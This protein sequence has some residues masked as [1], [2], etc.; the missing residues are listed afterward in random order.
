MADTVAWLNELGLGEYAEVFAEN[1]VDMRALP[2]LTDHDLKEFG[3]LLGHRR[4]V[5]AAVTQLSTRGLEASRPAESDEAAPTFQA[6]RRQVTVLFA[7]LSGYTELSTRIDAEEAHTIL[8]HFVDRVDA[9][10]RDHGGTVDKH[11]GDSV[12][13]VFGAPVAHGNDPERAVRVALAIHEA[14]P[15][16]SQEAGRRLHVHVGVASGQVVAS[17]VGNDAH[18]TVIGE[19]VNLA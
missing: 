12:M 18:Y 10:I 13:A 19:S 11:I 5:L 14:M 17:G 16:V 1:G 15:F 6:E 8:G 2:H 7:D 4:I 3:L 9:I